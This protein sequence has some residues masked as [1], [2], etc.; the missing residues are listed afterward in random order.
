MLAFGLAMAIATPA[1]AQEPLSDTVAAEMAGEA[2]AVQTAQ[3]AQTAQSQQP[4]GSGL[5]RRA[6]PPPTMAAQWPIFALFAATWV[7][8]VGYLLLSGRKV[9]RLAGRLAE[10]EDGR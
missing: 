1:A 3:T 8:I 7:A 10:R 5:P 6:V 2:A 4:V 9:S